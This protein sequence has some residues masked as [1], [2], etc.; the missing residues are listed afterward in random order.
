MRFEHVSPRSVYPLVLVEVLTVGVEVPGSWLPRAFTPIDTVVVSPNVA[1][2]VR[3]D[4]K[5]SM[6][7][8]ET[9]PA[10]NAVQGFGLGAERGAYPLARW[11]QMHVAVGAQFGGAPAAVELYPS[12]NRAGR[13]CASTWEYYR[14]VP[15]SRPVA[16]VEWAKLG[17]GTSSRE[18][19][20][21]P[22]PDSRQLRCRCCCSNRSGRKLP[23]RR[24]RWQQRQAEELED[25]QEKLSKKGRSLECETF[26][27][28]VGMFRRRKKIFCQKA[29]LEDVRV[30]FTAEVRVYSRKLE[31]TA[32]SW[33]CQSEGSCCHKSVWPRGRSWM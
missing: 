30:E 6:F 15:L 33:R 12:G 29:P 19:S 3:A 25:V 28:E 22:R 32:G 5:R 14:S 20:C 18:V 13:R 9:F 17:L 4:P 1:V 21:S 11:K 2:A 8:L 10:A 31:F 24:K 7:G 26:K 23:C 27:F 16:G